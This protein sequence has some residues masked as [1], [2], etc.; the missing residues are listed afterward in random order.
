VK[1]TT[2]A[3]ARSPGTSRF[4]CVSRPLAGAGIGRPDPGGTMR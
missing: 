1:A 2:D 3:A 4:M